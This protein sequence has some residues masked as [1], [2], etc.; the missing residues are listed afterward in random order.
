MNRLTKGIARVAGMLPDKYYNAPVPRMTAITLAAS[1]ITLTNVQAEN[2]IL[3]VTTGHATNAIIAPNKPGLM[4]W[5]VNNDG[6]NAVTIKVNGQ[7]GTT[8]AATK[9]AGVYCNGT[10]YTRLTADQ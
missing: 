1:A 3:E 2:G 5:V 9:R 7:T 10:D 8:I 4:F 6:V